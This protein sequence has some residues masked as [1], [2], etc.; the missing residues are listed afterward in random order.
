MSAA[1]GRRTDGA[2][3]RADAPAT[4]D[5]RVPPPG[6]ADDS[7]APRAD[8]AGLHAAAADGRARRSAPC[9]AARP[10]PARSPRRRRADRAAPTQRPPS[11]GSSPGLRRHPGAADGFAPEPG[12]RIE[13]PGRQPES[14]WWK[15]DAPRDPWR[16]PAA[17]SGSAAARSSPP[18]SRPSSIRRRTPSRAATTTPREADEDADAADHRP[19]G[20]GSGSRRSCSA[21]LDRPAGRRARRLRRLLAG[22]THPRRA[23]PPRRRASPQIGTPANRPPGSVAAIAKRVGPAVVSIA[24]T[25]RRE[26]RVR[27][28]LRRRHRQGRRTSSPT[29]TSSRR[30]P[31]TAARSSSRSRRGHAPRRRSS[32]ATRPATSP[33][34]KVPDDELTVATLGNSAKL[35]VGDPVIAIGSPLGLQGTVTAGIVSALNRPVHVDRRRRRRPTPTST[36]SRPTRRSTRA[37]PAARSSTRS[38]A[39]IGI[40]SAGRAARPATARAARCRVS[41]IGYAIPINYARDDRAAADPHRQGDARLAR[42]AGPHRAGRAAG[43]RLPRA[44]A[45]EAGGGQGRAAATAT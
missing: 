42:C 44:G 15:R 19:A 30:R 3:T 8:A 24:V 45:A 10:A 22:R 40:N 34:I 38:G 33:C 6:R 25:R 1:H 2:T 5:D 9:S 27:R 23:A 43:R 37:T 18:A 16:D 4:P 7:F 31:R 35:A 36:P 13:P 12:T 26:D 20:A 39:V 17:R 32:A 28:R 41:G 11:R 29:T 14:P 21:L